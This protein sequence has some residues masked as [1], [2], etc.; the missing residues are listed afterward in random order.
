M[1]GGLR[2]G[3]LVAMFQCWHW[4]SALREHVADGLRK[5]T[6]YI[7]QSKQ[8]EGYDFFKCYDTRNG[9]ILV[10]MEAVNLSVVAMKAMAESKWVHDF[11]VCGDEPLERIFRPSW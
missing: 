2:G 1:L 7:F 5:K 8:W 4:E 6:G 3:A 11:H 10:D 9:L